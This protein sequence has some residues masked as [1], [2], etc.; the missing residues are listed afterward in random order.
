MPEQ[1]GVELVVG[2]EYLESQARATQSSSEECSGVR[3]GHD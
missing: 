1:W 2:L 3:V